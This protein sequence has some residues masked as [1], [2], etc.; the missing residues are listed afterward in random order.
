MIEKRILIILIAMLLL[1]SFSTVAFASENSLAWEEYGQLV[2]EAFGDEAH[3]E[4][5]E[6]VDVKIWIPDKLVPVELTEEDLDVSAIRCYST[7][8]DS[9]MMY[10]TYIEAEG[11]PLETF[12]KYLLERNN[13]AEMATVN[14]IPC[15]IAYNEDRDVLYNTYLTTNGCLLQILFSPLEDNITSSLAMIILS[16]VQ[17]NVD[18]EENE[19]I[20]VNP[21]RELVHKGKNGDN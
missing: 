6:E 10:I 12:Q 9:F 18:K 3:F 13:D 14:E 8:D 15:V 4:M 20:S 21:V 7:V 1:F 16:S 5:L 2:E 19:S 17:P 11:M